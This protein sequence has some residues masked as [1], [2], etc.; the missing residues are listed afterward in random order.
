MEK[1]ISAAVVLDFGNSSGNAWNKGEK[2]KIDKRKR[3][4]KGLPGVRE[5]ESD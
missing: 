3:Y 1:N 4:P 5:V 2:T